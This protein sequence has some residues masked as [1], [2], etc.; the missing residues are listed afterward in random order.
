MARGGRAIEEDM[1]N[2][3]KGEIMAAE[4]ESTN[5]GLSVVTSPTFEPADV[6]LVHYNT[7]KTELLNQVVGSPIIGKNIGF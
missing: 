6:H 7:G 2:A 3:K 4:I 5:L 1:V